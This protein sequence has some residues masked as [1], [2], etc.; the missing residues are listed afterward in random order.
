MT[1]TPAA[2]SLPTYYKAPA[3][4]HPERH[5][6]AGLKPERNYGFARASNAVLVAATEMAVAARHYPIAFSVQT[7]AIPLAVLG[8]REGENLFVDEAGSWREDV[9]VP[10]YVR[11]Y[12]FIFSAEPGTQRLVLCVDEGADFYLPKA[13]RPFFVDGKP[14]PAVR[15]VMRFCESYQAQYEDTVKFGEWLEAEQLLDGKTARAELED[16]RVL[17]LSGFRMLDAQKFRA[18]PDDKVLELHRKGWLPLLHFHL[19]SLNNWSLLGKLAL[20]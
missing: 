14:S 9:Y 15:E 16:G 20:K 7:P 12:P 11:R 13:E 19:Q 4:L 1:A 6:Q 17:T 18:L 2:Q 8:L 5:A 10:A 3:P